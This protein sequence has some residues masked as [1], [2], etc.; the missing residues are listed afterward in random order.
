VNLIA[1][2]R[3]PKPALKTASQLFYNPLNNAGYFDPDGVRFKIEIV[4]C[5]T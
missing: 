1:F 2:G 3:Y 5:E 4:Q